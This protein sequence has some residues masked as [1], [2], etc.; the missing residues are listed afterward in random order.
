LKK[1]RCCDRGVGLN[2][3]GAGG[4]RRRCAGDMGAGGRRPVKGDFSPVAILAAGRRNAGMADA[5]L[6]CA[7]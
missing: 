3:G 2:C 6:L 1:S 5:A 7:V 4:F